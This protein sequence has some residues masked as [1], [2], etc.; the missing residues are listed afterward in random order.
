MVIGTCLSQVIPAMT[1]S[2]WKSQLEEDCGRHHKLLVLN[3]MGDF[4]L[5]LLWQSGL[6]PTVAAIVDK[7]DK[8]STNVWQNDLINILDS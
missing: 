4:V 8:V 2:D 7:A 5:E 3:A 6:E 1:F